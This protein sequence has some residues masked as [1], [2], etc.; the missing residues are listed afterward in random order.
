MLQI[1]PPTLIYL[2]FSIIQILFSIMNGQ[3]TIAQYKFI[4]TVILALLINMLYDHG[5]AIIA[6]IIVFVPFM[7]MTEL[8]FMAIPSTTANLGRYMGSDVGVIF[9]NIKMEVI[10]NP[11][12]P[13]GDSSYAYE[14][15]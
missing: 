7:L 4:A 9:P 2:C 11:V 14:S 8:W 12:P 3:P 13:M 6:W 5:L 10:E 15:K 1:Y